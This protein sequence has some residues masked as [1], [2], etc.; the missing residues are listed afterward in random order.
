MTRINKNLGGDGRKT[1]WREQL[2]S[3][4]GR[5]KWVSEVAGLPTYLGAA[6]LTIYTSM[7]F[8]VASLVFL[9]FVMIYHYV[10]EFLFPDFEYRGRFLRLSVFFLVQLL[11]WALAILVLSSRLK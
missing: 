2:S 6:A 8:L 3:F 1:T 4:S 7:N 10:Y 9:C 5:R 11:V